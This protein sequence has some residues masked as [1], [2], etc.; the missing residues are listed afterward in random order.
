MCLKKFLIGSGIKNF[1]LKEQAH[2]IFNYQQLQTL[3]DFINL[4]QFQSKLKMQF[5]IETN[6]INKIKN[7]LLTA[8]D[9]RYL[10]FDLLEFFNFNPQIEFVAKDTKMPKN[11]RYFPK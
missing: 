7:K 11:H 6:W 8:D 4:I 1:T 10:F 9:F 3:I 2:V 5:S